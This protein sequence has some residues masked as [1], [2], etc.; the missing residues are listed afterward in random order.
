MQLKRK[1]KPTLE[2]KVKLSW[3]KQ[4]VME[5]L[6]GHSKAEPKDSLCCASNSKLTQTDSKPAQNQTQTNSKPIQ[7]Y[8]KPIQSKFKL[9]PKLV[10]TRS[11]LGHQIPD[12]L[13][14]NTW[15]TQ[16]HG[17]ERMQ[18]GEPTYMPAWPALVQ[19]RV[20]RVSGARRA[21]PGGAPV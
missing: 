19:G 17:G 3:A 15:G 6:R 14:Q 16:I 2:L 13:D 9:G 7:T 1:L 18:V 20:G 11:K 21:G 10:Q 5:R 8:P 4:G 12:T